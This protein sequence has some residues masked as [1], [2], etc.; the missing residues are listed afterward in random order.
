MDESLRLTKI[1]KYGWA[2]ASFNIAWK[3]RIVCTVV[4]WH[5]WSWN[6]P[7]WRNNWH[8]NR[9]NHRTLRRAHRFRNAIRASGVVYLCCCSASSHRS[10][11]GLAGRPLIHPVS[12]TLSRPAPTFIVQINFSRHSLFLTLSYYFSSFFSRF[13]TRLICTMNKIISSRR[14]RRIDT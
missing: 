7:D 10:S 11:P 3:C 8:R 13:P 6:W 5:S 14:E 9:L 2:T 12:E 1:I 4:K